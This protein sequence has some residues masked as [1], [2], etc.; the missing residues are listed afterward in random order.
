MATKPENSD[1]PNYNVMVIKLLPNTEATNRKGGEVLEWF[2]DLAQ[3]ASFAKKQVTDNP[4]DKF[5]IFDCAQVL[6]TT[7]EVKQFYARRV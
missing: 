2:T 4:D 1:C 5:A 3:A 7:R 6:G